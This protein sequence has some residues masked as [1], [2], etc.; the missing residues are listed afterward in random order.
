MWGTEGKWQK[1]PSC[2][3][4]TQSYVYVEIYVTVL[5]QRVERVKGYPGESSARLKVIQGANHP[6]Y[7]VW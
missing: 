1:L 7:T 4:A 2:I 5:Q 6:V 3:E